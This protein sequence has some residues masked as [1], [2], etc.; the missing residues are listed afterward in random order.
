MAIRIISGISLVIWPNVGDVEGPFIPIEFGLFS[1]NAG[2][3][4]IMKGMV[5]QTST[6]N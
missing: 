3:I 4:E 1:Q 5:F 6:F 2:E